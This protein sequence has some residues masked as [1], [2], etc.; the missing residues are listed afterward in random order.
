MF[1]FLIGVIVVGNM[2]IIKLFEL[3]LNV[4]WVIKWLIN[5]IFDVNYIEVIEGGIEE[6]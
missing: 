1:E 5:E 3:I 4:V 2:V 6:M